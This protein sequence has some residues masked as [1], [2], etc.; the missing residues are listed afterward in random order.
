MEIKLPGKYSV[1]ILAV[2]CD[3]PCWIPSLYFKDGDDICAVMSD[4]MTEIPGI[5]YDDEANGTLCTEFG[6]EIKRI[7]EADM[8]YRFLPGTIP[9]RG[10]ITYLWR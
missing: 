5:H 4:T 3:S 2:S 6:E 1:L 7:G 8:A 10:G 9:K